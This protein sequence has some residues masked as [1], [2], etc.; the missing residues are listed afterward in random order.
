MINQLVSIVVV[1]YNAEKTIE[2][3]LNSVYMQTYEKIELIISDDGSKDKTVEICKKWIQI[4]QNRFLRVNLIE[5]KNAGVV[6][7]LNRALSKCEGV[8]IKEMSG[9]DLLPIDSIANAVKYVTDNKID[10]ICCFKVVQFYQ[11]SNSVNHFTTVVPDAYTEY[12]FSQ[13]AHKQ[14][15]TMLREYLVF[16]SSS[17]L[18]NRSFHSNVGWYDA[19]FPYVE[20][21]PYNL[22]ITKQGYKL[23]YCSDIISYCHRTNME[24]TNQSK[25]YF[26]NPRT[27]G[28]DGILDRQNEKYVKPYIHKYDLAFYLHFYLSKI[29]RRVVIE[30]LGNKKNN[31]SVFVNRFFL[32]L[33]PFMAKRKIY[34]LFFGRKSAGLNKELIEKVECKLLRSNNKYE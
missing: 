27:F 12:W 32:A 3:S 22:K 11:D 26:M 10:T 14:Y 33:D 18:I 34:N 24:S 30:L 23:Y 21:Y 1:T 28:I 5:E 8:W 25:R 6:V 9:D 17:A 16:P 31:I 20:D 4:H 7:N 13:S 2:E 29:R 15:R 19:E